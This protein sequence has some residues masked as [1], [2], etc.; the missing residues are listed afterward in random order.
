[1]RRYTN[2]V[3]LV[4]PSKTSTLSIDLGT[5]YKHLS[6]TI[7]PVVNNGI[8]ERIVSLPPRSGLIMIKQ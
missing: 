4:N 6:G 1:M 8:A 7:D 2:G 5:G 3:A